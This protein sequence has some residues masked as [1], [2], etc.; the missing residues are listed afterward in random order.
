MDIDALVSE[1]GSDK[2]APKAS[3]D[4]SG[5]NIDALVSEFGS[6]RKDQAYEGS[7]LGPLARPTSVPK[8]PISGATPEQSAAIN[9]EPGITG[10]ANPR[11]LLPKTNISE[12]AYEADKA[13]KET[14]SSGV[15]DIGSGHPYRG[16]GK[17]AFGLWQRLTSPAA[18][19]VEGG[20][21]TPA[22]DITGNPDIGARAGLIAGAVIPA[23][24]G[25]GAA[26]KM[27]PKNKALS[28]L[29]ESIGSENLP[30]VVSGMKSNPRLS[31]ADL[32]PKVLQ[33]TQ[34]LFANDGPQINY[35]AETS[36]NRMAGRPGAVKEAFDASTGLPVDAVQKLKALSDAAKAVGKKEIEPALA[37]TPHAEVTPVVNF[38][39]KEIGSPAMKSIKE[40]KAPALPLTDYQRELL[41]VRNKLRGTWPDRANMFSYSDQVHEIQSKLRA[42][43][44]TLLGSSTGSDRYLG[45]QLMDLRGKLINSIDK[46]SPKASAN[47]LPHEFRDVNLSTPSGK[48]DQTAVWFTKGDKPV[49]AQATPNG[50]KQQLDAENFKELSNYPTMTGKDAKG[51]PITVWYKPGEEAKAKAAVDNFT[52]GLKDSKD[53]ADQIKYHYQNGLAYGYN[54]TA[55]NSYVRQKFG[56]K[57]VSSA[58]GNK[59]PSNS[60]KAAL[61]NYRDE[62]NISEAFHDAYSG[63]FSN[64]KKLE[65]RPEFTKDWLSG[66]SKH[67]L[68]AAKEGARL[69]IDTEIRAAK[70][71]A[72]A[73]TNIVK[74]DF[75][76]EKLE[77]LFGK[78]EANTLIKKLEDERTI[79]NTHNKIVEGSQTAMRTASKDQ[80]RMPDKSEIGKAMLPTAILE[81]ANM[82]S[83]G[84]PG[85]GVGLM[86]GSKA[87][88]ATK[89]AIKMKLAREH[90][91]QYAK[92]ALPVEG[93]SRDE[94]IR[95][96]EARIP[97]P[98]KSLLSRA[99]N[100]ASRVGP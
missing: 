10:G 100:L 4:A 72:L 79:A 6:G 70:N 94:L 52:S 20:V 47:P 24:P 44:E 55:A 98:K 89:D 37:K 15:E 82:M 2:K 8:P 71:G 92:L 30:S 41:D 75:N 42:K 14:F 16:V 56:D 7:N 57:E 45:G 29:V 84:V 32:S 34:H 49:Y 68:E 69:A 62:K 88:N 35:L 1:F 60:Y 18:G 9:A 5:V 83:S 25:V 43:A 87:V 53:I 54:E 59:P 80:F 77:M 48:T 96:L 63:V 95:Q 76:K 38:I 81:G 17:A 33:D 51:N 97:G 27:L 61:S 65:N 23:V 21:T 78:A 3:A 36:A 91:A 19:I 99:S 66:L 22:T 11:S 46:A 40:G 13:G 31:P 85:V 50:A 12:A 67:E 26:V 90:N 39:D 74:S 28:T 64:S 86:I 73:G 58:L 93:P